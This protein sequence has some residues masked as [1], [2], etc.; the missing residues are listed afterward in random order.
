MFN[1][2]RCS[3]H[4]GLTRSRPCFLFLAAF[5]SIL[6]YQT[7][8]NNVLG[9]TIIAKRDDEDDEDDEDEDEDDTSDQETEAREPEQEQEA[10]AKEGD[11]EVEEHTSGGQDPTEPVPEEITSKSTQ[12]ISRANRYRTLCSTKT[13]TLTT[14][15][16]SKHSDNRPISIFNYRTYRFW[17]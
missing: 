4:F 1:K 8:C 12:S 7:F 2:T 10:I 5:L 17:I 14:M 11:E 3:D 16:P 13:W 9:K 15:L 6:S